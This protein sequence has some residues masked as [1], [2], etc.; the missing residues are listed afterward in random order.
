MAIQKSAYVDVNPVTVTSD[1]KTILA[2]RVEE[3][4]EGGLWHLPEGRV[5]LG[6]TFEATLN[7]R[8]QNLSIAFDHRKMVEDASIALKEK[9]SA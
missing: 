2:E 8:A 6:E 5:L 9:S 1:G 4:V 3:V 7:A